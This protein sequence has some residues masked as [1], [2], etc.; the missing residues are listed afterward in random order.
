MAQEIWDWRFSS[1]GLTKRKFPWCVG[2]FS[3]TISFKSLCQFSG[4]SHIVIYMCIVIWVYLWQGLWTHREPSGVVLSLEMDQESHCSPC[5]F[6]GMHIQSHWAPCAFTGMYPH[7]NPQSRCPP[8]TFSPIPG[9]MFLYY[10]SYKRQHSP[11][12]VLA[13]CGVQSPG[14]LV[15]L[16]PTC[17]VLSRYVSS[18]VWLVA[19]P[20]TPLG[21]AREVFPCPGSSWFWE[22]WQRH[23]YRPR[24]LGVRGVSIVWMCTLVLVFFI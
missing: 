19:P 13:R 6:T 8:Q 23:S 16:W 5:A 9:S 18:P 14:I 12:C 11:A 20:W 21:G 3:T 15:A 17:V 22:A 4:V 1:P 2:L 7:T 10:I 24:D